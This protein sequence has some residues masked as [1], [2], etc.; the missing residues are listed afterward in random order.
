M[1]NS[2]RFGKIFL[3]AN[4]ANYRECK[5]REIEAEIVFYSCSF[6]LFAGSNVDCDVAAFGNP[7]L[8]LSVRPT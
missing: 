5:L 1:A 8:M 6:A 4:H 3:P 7:Q 2:S